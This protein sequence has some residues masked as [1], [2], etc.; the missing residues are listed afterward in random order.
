[1]SSP[2]RAAYRLAPGHRT[3]DRTG[4]TRR[5]SR[6][7]RSS[8]DNA[9]ACPLADSLTDTERDHVVGWAVRHPWGA[10][11]VRLPEAVGSGGCPPVLGRFGVLGLFCGGTGLLLEVAVGEGAACGQG[12]GG[13]GQGEGVAVVEGAGGDSPLN[14]FARGRI[15]TAKIRRDWED[16]LRRRLDLGTVRAYDVVTMLQRDG[17][18]P[19]WGRRSR[20]TGGSSRPCTSSATSM[21]TK[22]IGATSRAYAISRKA[23]TR[24]PGRSATGRSA[25]CTTGTSAA[26]R[27]STGTGRHHHPPGPPAPGADTGAEELEAL[28]AHHRGAQTARHQAV[29]ACATCP[30]AGGRSAGVTSPMRAVR[31]VRRCTQ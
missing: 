27:T 2:I 12:D 25:S 19:R 10:G 20:C 13:D 28:C 21:S 23:A 14:A 5:R 31:S 26:W 7:L 22:L 1:M 18:P 8:Q 16:I 24:W 30:D 3:I 6:R 17:R 11:A 29:A 15:D 9:P 4:L